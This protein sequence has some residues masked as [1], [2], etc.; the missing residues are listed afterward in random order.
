MAK[1]KK[2]ANIFEAARQMFSR[3]KEKEKPKDSSG[4]SPEPSGA[5]EKQERAGESVTAAE[6]SSSTPSAPSQEHVPIPGIPEHA[7]TQTQGALQ[8]ALEE[9]LP[10][11]FTE[12]SPTEADLEPFNDLNEAF[13][14]IKKYHAELEDLFRKACDKAK[15]S[16]K[17]IVNF[18]RTEDNFAPSEWDFVRQT[19]K[20]E[21]DKLWKMAGENVK[22]KYLKRMKKKKARKRK[23]KFLGARRQGWIQVK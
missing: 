16:P 22:Q 7:S 20:E 2:P 15:L 6:P 12:L 14:K 11:V 23:G 1:E 9:P 8:Q 10:E 21:S 13:E 3:K 4:G 18:L 19:R 5:K 17:D